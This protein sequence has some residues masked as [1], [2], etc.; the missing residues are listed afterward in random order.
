MV[1]KPRFVDQI[2]AMVIDSARYSGQSRKELRNFAGANRPAFSIPHA[3]LGRG[4]AQKNG[5]W[6]RIGTVPFIKRRFAGAEGLCYAPV[7]GTLCGAGNAHYQKLY[8][9]RLKVSNG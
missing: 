2:G 6:Q 7:S 5:I 8:I 3:V 9:K 1:N 4:P